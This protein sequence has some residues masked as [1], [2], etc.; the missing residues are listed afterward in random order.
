M[1][2]VVDPPDGCSANGYQ[3]RVKDRVALL[4]RGGCGFGDKCL[5]AQKLGALAVIVV[6]SDDS[7]HRMM[8]PENEHNLVKIPAVMVTKTAGDTIM[9]TIRAWVQAHGSVGSGGA[10]SEKR[11][12][13]PD[14]VVRFEKTTYQTDYG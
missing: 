7:L 5:A 4:Q 10:G 2:V 6:N 8:V 11:A 3:V 9:M 12:I 1:Q 13:T 14:L